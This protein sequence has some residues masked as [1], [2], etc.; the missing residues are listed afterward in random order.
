MIEAIRREGIRNVIFLTGDRHHTELSRYTEG[1]SL[2]LYDLTV[3]PLT[4]SPNVNAASEPNTLRVEGTLV[5]ERNFATIDVEGPATR[6]QL[7]IRVFGA[8]GS[9]KWERIIPAQPR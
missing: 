6:R 8:D 7:R 4:S 9:L 5:M 3:S 2:V 1:D